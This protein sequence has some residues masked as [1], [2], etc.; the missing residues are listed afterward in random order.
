M[1]L[2]QRL[3]QIKTAR[4]DAGLVP[5]NLQILHSPLRHLRLRVALSPQGSQIGGVKLSVSAP[6]R[7]VVVEPGPPL[8][9]PQHGLHGSQPGSCGRLVLRRRLALTCVETGLRGARWAYH[10][11]SAQAGFRCQGREASV[12]SP[13]AR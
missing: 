6:R 10:T 1:A 4:V 3:N 5:T 13:S 7:Q 2:V 11:R 12:C 9:V 8:G